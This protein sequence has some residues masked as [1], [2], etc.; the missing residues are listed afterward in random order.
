LEDP[1]PRFIGK[2]L[3][4]FFDLRAIHRPQIV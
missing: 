2:S 3:G 4:D 1:K